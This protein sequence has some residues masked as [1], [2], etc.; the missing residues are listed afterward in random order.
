[1]KLS[2][3]AEIRLDGM[4]IL[5]SLNIYNQIILSF[6]KLVMKLLGVKDYISGAVAVKVV[7]CS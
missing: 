5:L 2:K 4:S 6:E 7:R 1:L 3:P